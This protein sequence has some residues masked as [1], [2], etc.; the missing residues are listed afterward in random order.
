MIVAFAAAPVPVNLLPLLKTLFDITL[1]RK[2]PDAIPRSAIILAIN[3]ALWLF[4]ALVALALIERFSETDFFLGI[5]SGIVGLACYAAI[6]VISGRSE[7]LMQSI[8]AIVGCGALIT[9]AFV[10]EYV[11]LTPLMG[12]GSAGL[13]ATLILFWSVPV[14]GHIIARAVDRH[15][16][17]GILMAVAVF[18]LQYVVSALVLAAP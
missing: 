13:V 9:L 2:G 6:I 7:R 3:V 18:S 12:E 16:Y 8:A 5:F 14:E 17:L 4:S 10:A 15:W 1:L 11:V